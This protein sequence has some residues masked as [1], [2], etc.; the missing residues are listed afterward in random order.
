MKLLIIIIIIIIITIIVF[1]LWGGE[2]A[3]VLS[4][5]GDCFS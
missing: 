3:I 2:V 5:W 1:M 4:L